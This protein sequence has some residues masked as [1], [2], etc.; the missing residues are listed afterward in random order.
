MLL[1]QKKMM[2]SCHCAV[3]PRNVGR[4][5]VPMRGATRKELIN[6]PMAVPIGSVR[7]AK[8]DFLM[9]QYVTDT[10]IAPGIPPGKANMLPVP[11]SFL[12]IPMATEIEIAYQGPRNIPEI[13]LIVCWKGN[14]LV[15]P[16]GNVPI[17]GIE[18]TTP[19]AIRTAESA[20]LDVLDTTLTHSPI[21]PCLEG[22]YNYIISQTQQQQCP[23]ISSGK[24][25]AIRYDSD[26]EHKT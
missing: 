6:A 8:S 17:P 3:R 23:L 12:I 16:T 18:R 26:W 5:L 2:K 13:A 1:I 24:I 19:K 25:A 11:I 14:T 20:I 10:I 15:G 21:S 4:E 9:Y 22:V 7:A